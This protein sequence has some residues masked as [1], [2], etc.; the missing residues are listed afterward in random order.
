[1]QNK[2]QIFL[3]VVMGLLL[4]ISLPL[5]YLLFVWILGYFISILSLSDNPLLIIIGILI[6]PFLILIASISKIYNGGAS[7]RDFFRK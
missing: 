1:M 6:L 4:A 7:I 3:R 5:L 2:K